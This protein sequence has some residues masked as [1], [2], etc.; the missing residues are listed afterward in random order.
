LLVVPAGR[1]HRF[2]L[3]EIRLGTAVVFID[4]PP[5]RIA[6]DTVLLDNVGGARQ[7]TEHLVAH[8]HRRIGIL[9]ESLDVLTAGPRLEGYR[10]AL[11]EAGITMDE[12]L[13]RYGC[14]DA[15]AARRGADELLGMDD[16]P[17]AIFATNNRMSV[18][19]VRAIRDRMDPIALVGF[20]EF[21][22]AESLTPPVTVVAYDLPAMGRR[23]AELLFD[24]IAGDARPPRRIIMPTWI[25]AR[26]SGELPATTWRR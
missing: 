24:R 10:Q 16:P 4:R 21:E 9:L 17:T 18:G 19:A 20:D 14:H 13:V 7:A 23:A 5:E 8:G 6:A 15:E 26:G 22:L 12:G 11:R 25:V 3:P 1:D 2:L